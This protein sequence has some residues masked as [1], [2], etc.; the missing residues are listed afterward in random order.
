M[1]DA[2]LAWSTKDVSLLQRRVALF[3][4]SAAVVCLLAAVTS[5]V[6]AVARD[7]LAELTSPSIILILVA[8][9]GFG[10]LA[11][12]VRSRPWT[13]RGLTTLETGGIIATSLLVMM[14]LMALPLDARPEL[15]AVAAL[16]Y[17]LV[18][19]AALVPSRARHTGIVCLVLAVPLLLFTYW[20]YSGDEAFSA[21]A[22]VYRQPLM[23]TVWAAFWWFL[24]SATAAAISRVVYG[25]RRDVQAAR[26]LGQ[27]TLEAKLGDGGMGE[28]WRASH[29]FL[30]RPAAIK[31][32]NIGGIPGD[33][34]DRFEREAQV[35]ATLESVHTVELYDFGVSDEGAYFHVMEL[36]SGCD[37]EILVERFGPQPPARVIHLLVQACDSLDEAHAAGLVHRDIKPANIFLTRKAGRFDF[38]KVLDFGLVRSVA[39]DPGESLKAT[40]DNEFVGTPAYM[41]PEMVKGAAL[42]GR[43]DLYCLACV[44]YWLLTGQLVF[45]GE[46]MMAIALFHAQEEPVPP[47]MR[48]TQPIPADLESVLM[49]CLA[50]DPA[51]RYASAADLAAALGACEVA[52]RWT[53]RHAEQWWSTYQPELSAQ[54]VAAQPTSPVVLRP[55]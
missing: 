38:V 4:A 15:M 13:K 12:V 20:R 1:T 37:L 9:V 40:R 42:D 54:A 8:A 14:T 53:N 50:K 49:R 23:A 16:T 31:M 30:R 52:G 6:I 11:L 48:A 3:A 5:A 19:R 26:Q 28:V 47:S 34:M 43:T 33:A 51:E 17:F 39:P 44:G 41:A 7:G 21:T 45:E 10:G 25:L 2:S 32:M 22:A 27:Y 29:R 24:S 36:L 55:A 46:T 18:L 35:T